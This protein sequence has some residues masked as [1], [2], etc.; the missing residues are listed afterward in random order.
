MS[1]RGATGGPSFGF[2]SGG[3]PGVP[4]PFGGPAGKGGELT[5][6]P[7]S[8]DCRATNLNPFRLEDLDPPLARGRPKA[9]AKTL[10]QQAIMAIIAH[11]KGC[12]A[13]ILAQMRVRGAAAAA[14]PGAGR[15]SRE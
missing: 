3:N 12:Y 11:W 9:V 8:L 14:E 1:L 10:K 4:C 2:C 6:R 7:L 13:I 5:S 15:A